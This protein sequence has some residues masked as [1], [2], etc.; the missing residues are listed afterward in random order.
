MRGREGGA[1]KSMGAFPVGSRLAAT[2][3]V[4]SAQA[5]ALQEGYQE[6]GER[7]HRAV[8]A[9]RLPSF[10]HP[11][12]ILNK[13]LP[14]LFL[15]FGVV[16]LL[17]IVALWRKKWW[18]GVLALVIFYLSSISFV[19]DRLMGVLE[20]RYPA[21][22][23]ASAGPADVIVVLG[24]ILGPAVPDG[25]VANWSDSVERF[26]AGVA[27]I[28]AG[29]AP[30][31]VFTGAKREWLGRETTEGAEL[32]RLAIARGVPAEKIAVTS[33]IDNTATEA[34]AIAGLLRSNGQH[35]IILVT[36]SWHIPRAVWLFRR[37]GVDC[38]PFPVDFHLDRTRPLEPRDFVPSAGAWQGTETALRELYG[39]AFYRIFR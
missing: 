37:A 38:Q 16:C 27:L 17:V 21:V 5:P 4:R 10:D 12:L 39:Y 29:R 24:G 35:R 32:R 28:Q 25:Y 14:L 1:S 34:A 31:L 15:P 6:S 9:R 3:R 22:P 19:S 2:S 33:L 30:Q 23:V 36:T 7:A 13:V 8:D 11:V 20:S 18:P 26:E